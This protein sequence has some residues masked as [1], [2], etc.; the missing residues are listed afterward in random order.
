MYNKAMPILQKKLSRKTKW[1]V[2]VVSAVLL[3]LIAWIVLDAIFDGPITHFFSNRQEIIELI[4]G[5][6]VLGPLVYVLIYVLST[7][8]APIPTPAI[9]V[10]GGYVFGTWGMLWSLIGAVLGF[11]AVFLIAR[12]LGKPFVEKIIKKEAMEKFN[13]FLG[14]GNG[15]LVFML[16]LLPIFPDGVLGYL[17]GLTKIPIKTL[18][19]MAVL[20]RLPGLVVSNYIGSHLDSGNY[21]LVAIITVV[22]VIITAV[23]Y[24][25]RKNIERWIKSRSK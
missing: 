18:M 10:A 17:T 3:A 22:F 6:T 16:F 12:K 9:A 13:N 8:I 7:V 14:K 5:A 21:W 19:W 20:G 2:A 1:Q 15:M 25:Q 23:F 11:Y 24:L 4:R